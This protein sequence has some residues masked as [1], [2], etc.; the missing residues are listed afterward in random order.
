LGAGIF[1]AWAESRALVDGKLA[2]RVGEI[3]DLMLLLLLASR[4][5]RGGPV[6]SSMLGLDHIP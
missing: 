2:D 6:A 4:L 1:P 3:I 5:A